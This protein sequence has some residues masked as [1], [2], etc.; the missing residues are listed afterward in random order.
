M[1]IWDNGGASELVPELAPTVGVGAA[2][3]KLAASGVVSLLKEMV[4]SLASFQASS[5]ILLVFILVFPFFVS[6]NVFASSKASTSNAF[7]FKKKVTWW[8]GPFLMNLYY[9]T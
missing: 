6:V 9:I 7:F 4:W 3:T 8:W 2:L 5:F 1:D